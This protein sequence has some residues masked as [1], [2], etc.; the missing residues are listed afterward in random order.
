M[1]CGQRRKVI[2]EK[3]T[4]KL[5]LGAG[6]LLRRQVRNLLVKENWKQ[7]DLDISYKE[8]KGFLDSDFLITVIGPKDQV[9]GWMKSIQNMITE[10][11]EEL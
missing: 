7:S 5:E 3:M 1:E 2:V 6:L 10:F 4:G 8:N 11:N 9:Q